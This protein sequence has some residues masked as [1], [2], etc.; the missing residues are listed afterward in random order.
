VPFPILPPLKRLDVRSKILRYART[1]AI[2]Y[3][4]TL[5]MLRLFES[6]F[7]FFPNVPGRLEGDWDP[8]GLAVEDVWL[9]TS[10]GVKLHAWWVPA[11]NARY[12]FLAFHGN[13]ANIANRA[14]IYRFLSETP[15]NVL[16]VEYRGYGKSEGS[17]SE[18][19][20]YRDAQAGYRYL[21]S[22]RGIAPAQII[23]Y[24]QSL[25]TAV[26][27]D[28]ASHQEVA[29]LVLEAPFPSA[30]A[31]ARRV[32]S[33]LPGISL[34]TYRQWD[35]GRKIRQVKAPVMIVH[36]TQD[37]VIPFAMGQA[38]YEAAHS[39]KTFVPIDAQCHEEA[40]IYS[41]GHYRTALTAFLASLAHP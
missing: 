3:L 8:P 36:C 27:T 7:V 31:M 34:L 22:Q 35:T 14:D 17:P 5:I 28:L 38:V 2:G 9:N 40:S 1:I 16:A 41:P 12:T 20:V 6:H 21:I 29:G 23:S 39:P 11:K 18:E 10:D 30:S 15:V 13:A 32:F 26:A 37:P 25:G 33:F 19:G 4:V 24:G